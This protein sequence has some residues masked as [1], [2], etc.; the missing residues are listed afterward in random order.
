[1]G[2]LVEHSVAKLFGIASCN[3]NFLAITDKHIS[4]KLTET[5]PTNSGK[6]YFDLVMTK[7]TLKIQL[8]F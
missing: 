8:E 2:T 5:V 6:V 3:T 4:A 7:H 1:M